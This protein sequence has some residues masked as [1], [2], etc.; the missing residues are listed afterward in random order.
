MVR[1][2][3]VEDLLDVSAARALAR[4]GDARA[5]R[6]RA[7]LALGDVAAALGVSSAAV[8][9]WEVGARCPSRDVAARYGALLAALARQ[10]DDHDSAANRVVEREG[11]GAAHERE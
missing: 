4:S 9:R 7:G 11:A 10:L 1:L 8:Q 6:L 2:A 5:L 3:T